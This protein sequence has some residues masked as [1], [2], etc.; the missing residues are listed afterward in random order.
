MD[1]AEFLGRELRRARHAIGKRQHD[2]GAEIGVSQSVVSRMELG[3]GGGM[4]VDLWAAA[5]AAVDRRVAVDM[6]EAR[7]DVAVRETP[8]RSRACHELVADMAR[9]GGWTAVTTIHAALSD[10]DSE[11]I[12]VRDTGTYRRPREV[13]VVRVW[14]EVTRVERSIETIRASLSREVRLHGSDSAVSALVV[15]PSSRSNRRRISE[16]RP[17]LAAAFPALGRD[18]FSALVNARR[19]MPAAA[20]ILWAFARCDRLRPAPLLPGWVWTSANGGP[21]HTRRA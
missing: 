18:W 17:T 20:G 1:P 19:P 5:A 3:R 2:V 6:V 7:A 9:R 12:L 13:A 8:A 14:D 4:S 16:S 11:T 10:A 21:R 15:I